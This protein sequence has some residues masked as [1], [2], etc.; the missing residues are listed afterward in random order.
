MPSEIKIP[1]AQLV[2]LI[3]KAL[4]DAGVPA[5]VCAVEAEVMAEA[6]LCGVPSHG[7][8]MLPALIEGIRDGRV[9]ANPQLKIIRER[10]ATCVLDGDNGPGRFVSVQAMQHAIERAQRAGIGACLATRVS[11]WGRAHAYAC[12]AAQAGMVG[13]CTTNAI[14]NMLA[15]GSTK[16][17]LGNNPLAIA[18]P[19]GRGQEPIVLD[20]AMSQ[21][22]VGKI[23]T[24]LREGKSVPDGWGLD[25]AG[26]PTNDPAA[27]L[28]GG[29]VLPFGD[30]K[31]AGLAFFMELLTGALSGG[32]FSYEI[33]QADATGLDSGSSKLFLALNVEAFVDAERFG[34]RVQD[35]VAWLREVEPGLNITLPGERGWQAREQH[36]AE[37][38]SLH[39]EIVAQLEAIGVSLKP[40]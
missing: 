39:A 14:P 32:L 3:A 18:V 15:W 36:L 23:R 26:R 30:H 6:D 33:A 16:P 5:P 40:G 34:E 1:H 25:S 21:A 31:G 35:L 38:I 11:H 7:V 28:G 37:G 27:I 8:R 17:L 22:A 12:R 24:Y 29:K 20:M 13:I 9:T 19:R 4:T 2:A 10:L